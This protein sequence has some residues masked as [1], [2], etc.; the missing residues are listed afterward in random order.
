MTTTLQARRRALRAALTV[1]AER[2]SIAAVDP[3]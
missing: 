3:S 2:G 1:H